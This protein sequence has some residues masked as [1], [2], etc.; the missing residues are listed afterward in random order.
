MIA[1]LSENQFILVHAPKTG[2]SLVGIQQAV[3]LDGENTKISPECVLLLD[4]ILYKKGVPHDAKEEVVLQF[5]IV[6]AMDSSAS[7][8][9]MVHCHIALKGLSQVAHHVPATKRRDEQRKE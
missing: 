1:H 6:D 9:A 7:V 2:R 3:R 5:K 4:P 8:P